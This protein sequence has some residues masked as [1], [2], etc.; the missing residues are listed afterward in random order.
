[1]NKYTD[2]NINKIEVDEMKYL[3]SFQDKSN[4]NS[5][6]FNYF[7]FYYKGFILK[8]VDTLNGNI[9]IELYNIDKIKGVM[10]LYD[11]THSTDMYM[12]K[13]IE[14]YTVEN[15][16]YCNWNILFEK[17]NKIDLKENRLRKI[18]MFL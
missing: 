1:M 3:I 12:N 2:V 8:I 10:N 5:G 17:F 9:F 7:Y 16:T 6:N 4:F 13:V 14:N 11:E 15:M 18:N